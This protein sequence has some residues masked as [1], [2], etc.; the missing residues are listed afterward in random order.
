M[1]MKTRAD[2][3]IARDLKSV[4]W[5]KT[6]LLGGVANLYRAMRESQDDALS[7]QLAQIIVTAYILGRRLGID[8]ARL[9]M[10]VAQIVRSNAEKPHDFEEWYGDFSAL[11]KHLKYREG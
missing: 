8:C 1:R 2:V 10:K 9:E 4:E 7:E 6:E 3:D 5:L 11:A